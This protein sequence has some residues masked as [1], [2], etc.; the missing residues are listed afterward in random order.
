[1]AGLVASA[2]CADPDF[3]ADDEDARRLALLRDDP[4]AV[5]LARSAT[6]TEALAY[7]K[8]SSGKFEFA[9]VEPNVVRCSGPLGPEGVVGLVSAAE[10]AAWVPTLM[11]GSFELQKAFGDVWATAGVRTSP[12]ALDVRL[13]MPPHGSTGYPPSPHEITVG[14]ACV[15]AIA[16]GQP[17]PSGCTIG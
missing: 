16:T 11:S 10:E 9:G 2:G 12:S 7:Y 8:P 1:M 17:R 13:E 15:D 14:R 3:R 5:A 4:L 6:C